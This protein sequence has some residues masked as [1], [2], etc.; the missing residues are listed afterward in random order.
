M[1]RPSLG[2]APK[3]DKLRNFFL[4]PTT[5]LASFLE[6]ESKDGNQTKPKG[7]APKEQRQIE[8]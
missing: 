8:G 3:V 6:Q 4:T 5:E 2:V 7:P 1:R